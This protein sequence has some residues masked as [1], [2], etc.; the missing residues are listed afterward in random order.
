MFERQ[1]GRHLE[2][3]VDAE[4][5][6]CDV[7]DLLAD[8]VLESKVGVST[9]GRGGLRLGL[10]DLTIHG[11]LSVRGAWIRRPIPS[12]GYQC[13]ALQSREAVRAYLRHAWTLL[14]LCSH[15]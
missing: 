15:L 4:G 3:T 12:K 7:D 14:H 13:F 9:L 10:R 1:V 5:H 2:L 6:F 11:P 8:P